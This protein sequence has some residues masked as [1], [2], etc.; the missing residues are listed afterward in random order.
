MPLFFD[1]AWFDARLRARGLD[2]TGLAALT[3]LADRELRS[4]FANDRAPTTLELSALAEALGAD[5]VEVALH[6]G[7]AL[8]AGE[9]DTLTRIESIEARLDAMD[10]WLEEFEQQAR[11]RA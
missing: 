5:I 1:A 7:V 8:R 9:G 2:R 4:I 10:V 3:G 11:M 6:A